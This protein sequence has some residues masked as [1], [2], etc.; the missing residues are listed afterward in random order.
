M[1]IPEENKK[2]KDKRSKENEYAFEQLE[3]IRNHF[4]NEHNLDGKCEAMKLLSWI[5]GE[6]IDGH[7]IIGKKYEDY[8]E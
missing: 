2:T 1:K 3:K 6:S 4:V 7:V 5:V 8:H